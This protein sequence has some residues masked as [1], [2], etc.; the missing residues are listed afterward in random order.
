MSRVRIR[1]A[2]SAD[3]PRLI[4]LDELTWSTRTTPAPSP[5]ADPF[6]RRAPEDHLVAAVDDADA[7]GGRSGAVVGYVALGHPTPLPA[8]AHVWEV[9]GLA[10]DPAAAGRGVGRA[11][12]D[13]AVAEAARRGGRKV[14]LR[15]LAH[16][17]VARRLYERAG[18]EVE[19]ILR[20]EFLLD[21][22]PVDD[23][24]MARHLPTAGDGR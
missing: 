8:S 14:S 4:E 13:A 5:G 7:A 20:G 12:V 23:V 15:V 9:Q 1:P 6:G 24:L 11:L 18:F 3:R 22:R 10:V 16:N 19:G 17:A 21:G 2:A